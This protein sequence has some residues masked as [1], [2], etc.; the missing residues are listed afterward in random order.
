MKKISEG[1]AIIFAII[2]L[3]VLLVIGIGVYFFIQSGNKDKSNTD[4]VQEE[5]S[6]VPTLTIRPL[7]GNNASGIVTATVN[8][9]PEGTKMVAFVITG[10]DGDVSNA[11]PNLGYDTSASDGWTRIIDTTKYENGLYE[12]SGLPT[13][14]ADANPLTLVSAQVIIE[15]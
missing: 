13:T 1:K 8:N 4:V 2:A 12:V 14:S 7:N 5:E 9:A 11:G 3:V 6:T 15:N 10:S